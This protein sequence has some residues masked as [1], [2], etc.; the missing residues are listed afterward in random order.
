AG[1]FTELYAPMDVLMVL[2]ALPHPQDPAADYLP[3]PVQL[4]WY[5]ADDMQAVSE[6]MVTRGENQRA[7]H[8]TQL[9][10]L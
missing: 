2:T 1:D 7:L 5:Q 8:N 10:A 9:F 4:S 3:R 6:A